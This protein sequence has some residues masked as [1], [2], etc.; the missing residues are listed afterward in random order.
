MTEMTNGDQPGPRTG[1]AAPSNES[2]V[3]ACR[4]A[5]RDRP[6]RGL[7]AWSETDR[8]QHVTFA[9]SSRQQEALRAV[10]ELGYAGTAHGDVGL[11]VT[12]WDAELLAQRAHRA[13]VELRALEIAHREV[14]SATLGRLRARLAAGIDKDAAVAAGIGETQGPQQAGSGAADAAP[15]W[16]AVPITATEIDAASGPLRAQLVKVAAAEHAILIHHTGAAGIASDVRTL[17]FE[18]RDQRGSGDREAANYAFAAVV[19][20]IDSVYEIAYATLNHGTPSPAALERADREEAHAAGLTTDPAESLESI[21]ATTRQRSTQAST[22][23]S[24]SVED[25]LAELADVFG[26][27]MTAVDVGGHVTC[28]EADAIARALL[29]GGHRYAASRWL[30]GHARG[31]AEDD[32]HV[33]DGFDLDAYLDGLDPRRMVTSADVREVVGWSRQ[34]H[35]A[36]AGRERSDRGAVSDAPHDRKEWAAVI[37][38]L[39]GEAVVEDPAWPSLTEAIDRAHAAGWDVR[40]GVPRLV[41]R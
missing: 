30:D 23:R 12:G 6:G 18:Y 27:S 13:R 1:L 39:A 4:W 15:V 35:L 2:V 29:A 7:L 5:T 10:R 20:E 24:R 34:D 8:G 14:A 33:G 9:G 22:Q 16:T 21:R 17:Y 25:T 40:E 31:D 3:A 26:D 36:G 41:A 32:R 28:T 11:V 19:D 38:D 37:R